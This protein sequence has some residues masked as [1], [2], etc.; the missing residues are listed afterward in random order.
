MKPRRRLKPDKDLT[1]TPTTKDHVLEGCVVSSCE[2]NH[3]PWVCETFKKLSVTT[4]KE[5]ITKEGRCYRC[6]AAG[7]FS[8][9]CSRVQKCGVEGCQ[10]NKHS[11]YLHENISM[12]RTEKPSQMMQPDT[13]EFAQSTPEMN[14][15]SVDSTTQKERGHKTYRRQP[16]SNGS[17]CLDFQWKK[18]S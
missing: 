13:P 5:L 2:E 7:H 9:S 17:P 3:P 8:K 6:L 12:E 10:S 15:P 11:P 14:S 1:E 16:I 4:R 18:V